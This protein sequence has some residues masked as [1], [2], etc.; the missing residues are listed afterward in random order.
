MILNI[1][2][3]EDETLWQEELLD[4]LK[5]NDVHN[6]WHYH[7]FSS[8]EDFLKNF[9]PGCYDLIF[10]DIYMGGINGVETITAIRKI[11]PEVF[12]AFISTSCDF[13]MEGY[14]LNVIKYL[15]KPLKEKDV[16]DAVDLASLK[17]DR[18]SQIELTIGGQKESFSEDTITYLEQ[19]NKHIILNLTQGSSKTIT[20]KLDDIAHLFPQPPFLRCHKSYLV[21]LAQVKKLDRT[22][23][24]FVLK[25]GKNV[26]I[27]RESLKKASKSFDAYIFNEIRR[28]DNER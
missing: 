8:G 28:T 9:T 6:Q 24:V 7:T 16:L 11:D 20:G 18:Q 25:N 10:M 5:K 19:Q 12:I 22:L 27:R 21:N 3:C 26:Y 2:I 1:A 4:I 23:Q 17:K 14:R 13:A 15:E